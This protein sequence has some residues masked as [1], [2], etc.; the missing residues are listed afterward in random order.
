MDEDY[1]PDNET[2]QRASSTAR[3]IY[4][5]A[6][7]GLLLLIVASVITAMA[8]SN[9]VVE[10]GADQDSE[11]VDANDLKPSACNGL[12]LTNVVT[13]GTGT[14]ANDLVVGDE[15]GNILDGGDGADCLVGGNGNDTLTGGAGDD[16]LI[17]GGGTDTCTGEG[18]SDTYDD[19]CETQN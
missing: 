4:R 14:T 10:S 18:G 7:F 11:S 17:G 2:R 3:W 16:V 12:N 6:F 9:T 5:M 13:D 15:N 8:T 1:R 19:S